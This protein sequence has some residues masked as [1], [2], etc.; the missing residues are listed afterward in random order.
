M[1][2]KT[3][4]ELA[5]V[6]IFA[7]QR[8]VHL[9]TVLDAL[10]KENLA[11]FT[12]VKIFVDGPKNIWQWMS[13]KKVISE[14]FKKRNFKS[15][16]VVARKINLGLAQS[17]VSGVNETLRRSGSVIVLEDDT[18]PLR[19]FL[20]YMNHALCKYKKDS[21]I[22]QVSGFRP[23]AKAREHQVQFSRL[24]TSWGWGT[25]S[26][27]WKK[28]EMKITLP[29]GFQKQ[30]TKFNFNGSYPFYRLLLDVIQGKSESWAIRWYFACFKCKSW[31]V[32]PPTSY[33][34]NI[35]FDGS[36]EHGGPRGP[37]SESRNPVSPLDLRWSKKPE[38][39]LQLRNDF[40]S[41]LKRIR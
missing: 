7:H 40:K 28:F 14:A 17:I 37:Q 18:V 38:L 8:P 22:F 3:K 29:K 24:T 27:A 13:V 19:G 15:Q 1:T 35:G 4:N 2:N 10:N 32:Y 30:I 25:W 11:P 16:E 41:F 33:I 39:N 21:R 9:K 23:P 20:F 12:K 36:G 6:I 34:R 31:I 5:P 26:R